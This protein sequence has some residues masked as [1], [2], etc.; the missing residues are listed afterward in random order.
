LDDAGM[1]MDFH[2]IK[3]KLKAILN[4]FDHGFL[5]DLFYFKEIN[6]T[7][8]NLAKL[9]FGKLKEGLPQITKVTV[10]ESPTAA[11]SYC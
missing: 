7:S 5:N 8:E 4:E 10:W 2:E 11:A 9:I 6:P 3:A 1:M